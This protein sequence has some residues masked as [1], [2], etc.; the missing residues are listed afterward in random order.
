MAF[1]R[2]FILSNQTK[3]TTENK[4]LLKKYTDFIADRRNKKKP[5]KIFTPDLRNAKEIA[6]MIAAGGLVIIPWGKEERRIFCLIGCYDNPQVTKL[7]NQVKGRPSDQPLAVGCLPETTDFVASVK[8]CKP[9][10]NAATRLFNKSA[11][12]VRE[13]DLLEVLNH[14]YS[15]SVGLILKAK[16]GIPEAVTMKRDGQRTVLI[17]GERDYNLPHDIYNQTLLELATRYGKVVAGTSANPSDNNVYSIFDQGTAYR[18][19]KNKIDGFVKFKRK[20]K[21]PSIKMFLTSST[22]IDLIGNY[23]VATRW[24]NLH[25]RRFKDIFPD[26][27]ISKNIIKNKNA[28]GTLDFI[29]HHVRRTARVLLI[30]FG[31]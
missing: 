16:R 29:L 26:L 9:L 11:S 10:I 28:E 1:Y 31:V 27:V 7:M 23:P 25:P 30:K 24:G 2:Q 12:E 13:K 15:R 5:A 6:A 14:C 17:A 21:P 18:R 22:I 19:F 4:L 20:P 3:Q 8:N